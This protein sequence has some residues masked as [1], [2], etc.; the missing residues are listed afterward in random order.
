MLLALLYG[1][2]LPSQLLLLAPLAVPHPAH[3]WVSLKRPLLLVLLPAPRR[4]HRHPLPQRRR[5]R[6]QWRHRFVQPACKE[7]M[8]PAAEV[9]DKRGEGHNAVLDE[10]LRGGGEGGGGKE[11]GVGGGVGGGKDG[12]TD[13]RREKERDRSGRERMRLGL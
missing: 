6:Q 10:H 5:Q 1:L 11:G 4:R 7:E 13:G 8:R 12:G 9:G 2:L 3:S